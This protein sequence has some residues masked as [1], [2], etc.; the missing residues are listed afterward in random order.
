MASQVWSLF[1]VQM[2]GCNFPFGLFFYFFFWGNLFFLFGPFWVLKK[3]PKFEAL[4]QCQTKSKI[5]HGRHEEGRMEATL[6]GQQMI[7]L[8]TDWCRKSGLCPMYTW[9]SWGREDELW[10]SQF[11]QAAWGWMHWC[12][13]GFFVMHANISCM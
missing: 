7:N 4:F 13:S 10:I 6:D 2:E 1:Y 9:T 3:D 11:W 12:L 5:T 8:Y